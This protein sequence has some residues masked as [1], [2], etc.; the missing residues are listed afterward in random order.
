MSYSLFSPLELGAIEIPNR[1]VMAPMTRLRADKACLA[2]PEMVQYYRQR[3]SAGLIITEGTHPGPLGRGYTCP[4]GIHNQEQAAA[5]RKVT[6]AVHAEGGHIFVQLMH[7]GRVT[8]SSLL[9]GHALPVA[10]SAIAVTGTIHTFDGKVPFETPRALET[11]EVKG[12]V[13]EYRRAAELALSAGFDGVELHAATGYL[14]HQFQASGSNQRTDIY[15][16]SLENRT[17]FTL[18]VVDALCQ[19]WGANKIG[20]KIAP[21]YTVNDIFDEDPAATYIYL[22][23]QLSP[24]GLAY[25]HVGYESGYS[26]GTGPSF[27]P[28]DLLR[29]VYTGTLLAAGGFTKE[30][31]DAIIASG[32]ADGVV[33]GRLFISNPDLVERFRTNGPSNASDVSTFYGGGSH[34]YTDYPTLSD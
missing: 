24:L 16:G 32:R 29:S 33:F 27:N 19:V 21:G 6:D 34:G 23:K 11:E 17:R 18:E 9:P 8:H 10:P 13:A 26:R 7:A 14:P 4:P 3:A 5:W 30:T 22:A 31:G 15:G 25:L 1:I 20:I 2:T 28:I 12:I